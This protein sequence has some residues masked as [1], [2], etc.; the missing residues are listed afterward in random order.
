MTDN[1]ALVLEFIG[2]WEAR[3]LEGILARMT[4]DVRYVNV[5]LSEWVG[6]EAVREGLAPFLGAARAARWTVHHIAETAE[7]AVLTERTDVFEM[8]DRT[9]TVPVMG[10]FEIKGGLIAAWRDYFDAISFQKQ[11]S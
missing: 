7:G 1:L 8:A 3:D 4:P 2:A 5:G 11:M 6:R 10:V 9:L